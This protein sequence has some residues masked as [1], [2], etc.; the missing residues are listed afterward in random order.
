MTAAMGIARRF[1]VPDL[2]V[3]Q[4]VTDRPIPP[5]L[6]GQAHRKYTLDRPIDEKVNNYNN[7]Y[8]F[9]PTKNIARAAQALET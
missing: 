1:P 8:E 6:S 5:P 2:A 9:M 4:R 7:F 3:A